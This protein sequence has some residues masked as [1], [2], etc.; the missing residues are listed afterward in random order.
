VSAFPQLQSKRGVD[1]MPSVQWLLNSH[2]IG[3]AARHY[4]H[5][6]Q[7]MVS[8]CV[9]TAPVAAPTLS[10]APVSGQWVFASGTRCWRPLPGSVLIFIAF[11][12]A[13]TC[14]D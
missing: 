14:S 6:S 3:R 8:H 13:S 2:T 9:Y 10:V 4:E 11:W 5:A 1:G 7:I 12:F